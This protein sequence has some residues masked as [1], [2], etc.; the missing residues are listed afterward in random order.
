M[1]LILNLRR[2]LKEILDMMMLDYVTD[3]SSKSSS[4]NDEEDI[5]FIVCELT[6]KPT[7]V[8][9]P[10]LNFKDVSSLDCNDTL[11]YTFELTKHW[12]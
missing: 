11:L 1:L 4:S 7:T 10:R 12:I 2:E 8:L 6:C 3:D 5:D 9:G